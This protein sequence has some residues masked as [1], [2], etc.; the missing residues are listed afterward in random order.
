MVIK[1]TAQPQRIASDQGK[2]VTNKQKRDASL[3]PAVHS[4]ISDA[5]KHSP[6]V[7]LK[8][9]NVAPEHGPSKSSEVYRKPQRARDYE[10]SKASDHRHTEAWSHHSSPKA[11]SPSSSSS[12]HSPDRPLGQPKEKASATDHRPPKLKV[13][14]SPERGKIKISPVHVDHS[15]SPTKVGNSKSSPSST[16]SGKIS[17]SQKS[18]SGVKVPKSIKDVSEELQAL[19]GALRQVDEQL[20]AKLK[21]AEQLKKAVSDPNSIFEITD[22]DAEKEARDLAEAVKEIKIKI[23]ERAEAA[24]QM[25]TDPAVLQTIHDTVKFSKKCFKRAQWLLG[26]SAIPAGLAAI[27]PVTIPMGIAAGSIAGAGAVVGM[28]GKAA[29]WAGH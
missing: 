3:S 5:P 20:Q 21:E 17:P 25:T 26:L 22:V 4:I 2:P 23:V 12:E 29:E 28:V 7:A 6:S 18:V 13:V 10:M 27:P 9:R 11:H 8:S 14:Q 19:H 16:H 15:L 1:T 24:K